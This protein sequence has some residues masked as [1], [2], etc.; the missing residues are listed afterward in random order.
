M[1]RSSTHYKDACNVGK[2]EYAAAY[3]TLIWMVKAKQ[4]GINWC[5]KLVGMGIKEVVLAG[6]GDICDIFLDEMR[7]SDLELHAI[8]ESNYKK[9]VTRYNSKLLVDYRNITKDF[10]E[11]KMI[12]VCQ[13]DKYND[14]VM[15]LEKYAVIDNIISL[16]EILSSVLLGKR[17]NE[18]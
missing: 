4:L 11:A 5:E 13:M 1:Y 14:W 10:L 2:I 18:K 6:A 12:I 3:R 17:G 8:L 16:E 7:N 15:K 9:Y